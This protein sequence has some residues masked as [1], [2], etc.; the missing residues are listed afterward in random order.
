MIFKDEIRIELAN[1]R[2]ERAEGGREDRTRA[3]SEQLSANSK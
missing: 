2:K 1:S 3:E